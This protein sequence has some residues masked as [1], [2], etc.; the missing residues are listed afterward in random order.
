MRR[1]PALPSEQ[2]K[3]RW[4][5]PINP[6]ASPTLGTAHVM[7]FTYGVVGSRWGKRESLA[8]TGSRPPV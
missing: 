8:S 6:S 3:F 2:T 5:H 4:S 7:P 1:K